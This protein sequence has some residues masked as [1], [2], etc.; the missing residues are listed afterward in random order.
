VLET[1]LGWAA[2]GLGLKIANLLEAQAGAAE[3][4]S[5]MEKIYNTSGRKEALDSLGDDDLQQLAKNLRQ[6]VPMAT[7]VFDGANEDEIK[8]MLA[9]ADL[10]QTGQTILYDGRTGDCFD[11]PMLKLNHL[12]DD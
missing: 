1:H 12:V 6:G 2:R 8:Q 11:R 7:P 3:L 4:R 5:F 10:P 9:L